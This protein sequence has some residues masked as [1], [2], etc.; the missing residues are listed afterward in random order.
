MAVIEVD[1]AGFAWPRRSGTGMAAFERVTFSAD[2]G[3]L[4]AIL[5]PSGCGKSSLLQCLAGLEPLSSGDIRIADREGHAHP[6]LLFQDAYLFPWLT[7]EANVRAGR[8]LRSIG[9]APDRDVSQILASIGM[10]ESR[11]LYPHE[12]SG[13]MRQRVALGRALANGPSILLMDEPFSALDHLSRLK[14]GEFLLS[15]RDAFNITTLFVTHSVDEAIML[16][17]KIVMMRGS[18]GTVSDILDVTMPRPRGLAD[19][20][21]NRLR[22]QLIELLAMGTADVR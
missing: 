13:G 5:G 18:P 12:L 22:A 2:P 14:M 10:T 17:D 6:L 1:E 15:V 11:G 21:F 7:V 19:T 4:V 8:Q 16:A 3:Q 20:A 9:P